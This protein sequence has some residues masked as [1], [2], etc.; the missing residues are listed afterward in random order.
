MDENKNVNPEELE[1][2]ESDIVELVDEEGKSV[3]FRHV[4]TIDYKDE[5]FVFFSPVE[6]IE[7]VTEDEVVIFNLGTDETGA[8]VFYPSKTTSFWTKCMPSI[9]KLWK[10]RT[11]KGAAD[12]VAAVK[13][14]R[15]TKRAADAVAAVTTK[16]KKAAPT[17]IAAAVIAA[18]D[19]TKIRNN[20]TLKK[21]QFC[22]FFS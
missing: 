18:A 10:K 9:S 13:T 20:L 15:T 12:A 11:A 7:G 3:N 6:E 4:A 5:W 17:K 21:P 19:T 14:K 16:R 1:D 8:D 2:E 22:G